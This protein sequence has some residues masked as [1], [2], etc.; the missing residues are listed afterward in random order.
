MWDATR[1]LWTV[2]SLGITAD[3]RVC[4]VEGRL[5]TV[6]GRT[7]DRICILETPPEFARFPDPDGKASDYEKEGIVSRPPVSSS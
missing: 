5:F 3:E 6:R 1:K 7:G 2:E 4:A